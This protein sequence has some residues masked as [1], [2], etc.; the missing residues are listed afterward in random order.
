MKAAG[1]PR[2]IEAPLAAGALAVSA[3]VILLAATATVL[4]SGGPVIFRQQRVGRHG[5]LF[6]MFKLR[7]MVATAGGPSVTA[8]GDA[9]V[10]PVGRVLRKL[11]VDELPELWNVVIGD[12][13][14]VGPR[15]E[16]PA[17]VDLRDPRW[18]EALSSAPGITDPTT[19]K[20]RDE[21]AILR[22]AGGS[23]ELFYRTH[24][25]PFKLA[26][27]V[28]YQR[29]RTWRSDLLVLLRTAAAA[30][31]LPGAVPAADVVLRE[32]TGAQDVAAEPLS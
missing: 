14:R 23:C 15:P 21:E 3:P 12:M 11:K 18:I 19:L 29:I 17:L 20:L 28:E 13:R 25:Q 22:A 27:Y 30:L 1:L 4:H 24:L 10:T 7:S 5:R 16:L 8:A 32:I 31:R 26:G 9:R 6:T 2:W